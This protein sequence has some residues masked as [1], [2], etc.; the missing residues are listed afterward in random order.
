MIPL[1]S[2]SSSWLLER[3]PVLLMQKQQTQIKTRSDVA[4]WW[5]R[6]NLKKSGCAQIPSVFTSN[7]WHLGRAKT[8]VGPYRLVCN[9]GFKRYG[10]TAWLR[11]PRL[12]AR[13]NSVVGSTWGAK[14]A[15][16]EFLVRHCGH[17]YH[18]RRAD[19]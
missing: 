11:P 19:T 15:G 10:W 13:R 6:R 3:K 16:A 18:Q 17:V 1:N 2:S 7:P 8:I 14:L 5:R 9:S 4:R 12:P